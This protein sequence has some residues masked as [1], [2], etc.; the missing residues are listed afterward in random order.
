MAEAAQAAWRPRR[1]LQVHST[2][3]GRTWAGTL[4]QSPIRSRRPAISSRMWT[5]GLGEPWHL[6]EADFVAP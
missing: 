1:R 5:E 2:V 3:S 4:R 6:S